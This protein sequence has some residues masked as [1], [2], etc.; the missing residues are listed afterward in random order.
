MR[1]IYLIPIVLLFFACNSMK[2]SPDNK[3]EKIDLFTTLYS[4]NYNGR[5]TASNLIIKNQADLNALFASVNSEEQPKVDFSNNQVVALFLGLKNSGGYS[6][7]IDRVEEEAGKLIVYKKVENPKAG[8]NATMALT[9]PLVIAVIHS[10]KELI[11][12]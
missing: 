10:K 7:A 12:R 9:N 11:F 1:K 6:I 2:K 5:D 4:S 8:E 3:S